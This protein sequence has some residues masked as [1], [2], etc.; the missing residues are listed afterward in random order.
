MDIPEIE[1]WWQEAGM[2]KFMPYAQ[3]YNTDKPLEKFLLVSINEIEPIHRSINGYA[4]GCS[5]EKLM[6]I[7]EGFINK[8]SLPPVQVRKLENGT[9]SYT[10]Y[11]GYHR[12]YASRKAG[13]THIPVEIIPQF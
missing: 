6:P 8:K 9:F 13:F 7:C 12:L 5:R 4:D 10:L 2:L 11:D 1:K 3:F